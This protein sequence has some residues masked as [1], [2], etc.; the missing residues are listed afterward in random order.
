M[1]SSGDPGVPVEIV[2]FCN[3]RVMSQH[4]KCEE[5]VKGIVRTLVFC[6]VEHFLEFQR[7]LVSGGW[8]G[9]PISGRK[10]AFIIWLSS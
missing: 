6:G 9:R 4:F 8:G 1:G 2:F 5:G 7:G 10:S 3:L